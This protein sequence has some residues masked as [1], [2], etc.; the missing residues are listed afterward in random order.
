MDADFPAAHSMDTEWFAVDRDGQV[1]LF[2]TGENGSMPKRAQA[3]S[4][5]EVLR[6]LG[7]SQAAIEALDSSYDEAL[8]E[9]A[10]L[11][12]HVYE[13]ASGDW[14]S[15]PYQRTHRPAK[16]LHVDQL[17]PSLRRQA[18]GVRLDALRFEEKDLLQPSDHTEGDAYGS[19]YLAEDGKTVRPLPGKEKQ[20]RQE[21]ERLRQRRPGLFRKYR[22]EG[23]GEGA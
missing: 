21:V 17:P 22:F 18:K 2:L 13:D 10:R 23:L 19:G 16:P 4:M 15:G 9:L 5:D 14:F 11:G 12:L 7:G 20:Y 6:A 8:L 3:V 1:A